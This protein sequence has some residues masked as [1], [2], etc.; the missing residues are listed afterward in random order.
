ME[1]AIIL[2]TMRDG[3]TI[4]EAVEGFAAFLAVVLG[5]RKDPDCVRVRWWV[6]DRRRRREAA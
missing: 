6:V 5:F 3:T 1:Q 2:A 4:E